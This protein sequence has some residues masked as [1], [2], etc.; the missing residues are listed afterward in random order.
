[1]QEKGFSFVS[2]IDIMTEQEIPLFP[3]S[4]FL[5]PGDYSQ[6]YIFEDRYKQL[7]NECLEQGMPFGIPF[8]SKENIGNYGCLVEVTEVPKRYPAGEMDI[9]IKCLSVFKLGKFNFQ[10]E[11]KLYPAGSVSVLEDVKNFAADDALKSKFKEHMV[12]HEVFNSELLSKDDLGVFDIANELYLNNMEKLELLKCKG[13]EALNGY[14]KNYIYYLH[15]LQE[16]EKSVFQ[17]IYLN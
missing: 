15:L 10:K 16:Q 8:S 1:M 13:S 7:I 12:K 9:V 2:R 11:G 3:L 17:N 4:L 6:L 5:L 14:L